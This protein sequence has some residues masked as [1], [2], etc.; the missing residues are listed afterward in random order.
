V[1]LLL[2]LVLLAYGCWRGD[3]PLGIALMLLGFAAQVWVT[4]RLV[5]A[6]TE[7]VGGH[8]EWVR[9]G[10][11]RPRLLA[12]PLWAAGVALVLAGFAL[13]LWS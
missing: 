4:M 13:T 2:T 1:L 7:P 6:T 10:S 3:S 8:A 11:M 5:R 12:S 9:E